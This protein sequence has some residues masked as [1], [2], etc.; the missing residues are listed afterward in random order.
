MKQ[1]ANNEEANVF[2]A[3][4]FEALTITLIQVLG[5]YCRKLYV[6]TFIYLSLHK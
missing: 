4:D 5:R 2:H 6:Q 1:I 3:T